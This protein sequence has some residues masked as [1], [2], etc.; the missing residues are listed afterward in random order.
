MSSS[1]LAKPDAADVDTDAADVDTDAVTTL[2][3]EEIAQE[4]E[5]AL[6]ARGAA[7]A[8]RYFEIEGEATT[9]LK[10]LA[11]TQVALR[12]KLGDPRGSSHEYRVIVNDMYRSLGVSEDRITKMQGSVRWHVGNLLRRHMTPRELEK[13]DLQPASPLERLQDSRK[14]TAAIVK[15]A[16]VSSDVAASTPRPA[17]RAKGDAPA[18]PADEGKPVR[19]TADHLRLA[20]VARDIVGKLDRNVIKSHMT[21][22]QRAKL[23]A[24]LATMERKIAS[25]RKLTQKPRSKG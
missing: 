6:V 7:L 9:L 1:E 14:A 21:D 15:A 2:Q 8:R 3:L 18:V 17:K 12:I 24:E 19:A 13:Y 16:R 23:D 4:S 22:G 20:E 10:N 11:V 25:L 5:P